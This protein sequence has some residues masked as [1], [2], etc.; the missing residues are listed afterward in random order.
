MARSV[1]ASGH[2]IEFPAIGG[3]VGIVRQRYPIAPL[4]WEGSMPWK[5]VDALRHVVLDPVANGYLMTN[6]I[7]VPSLLGSVP[8]AVIYQMSNSTAASAPVHTHDVV[9][10]PEQL[11]PKNIS[12]LLFLN[13]ASPNSFGCLI[14]PHSGT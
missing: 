1:Q 13:L 5:E 3:G 7:N 8:G 6:P 4:F 14:I 11:V 9:L 12:P 10:L 2:W